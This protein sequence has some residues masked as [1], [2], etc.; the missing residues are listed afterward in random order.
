MMPHPERACETAAGKRGR[1]R[2]P[3]SI[4]E[5]VERVGCMCRPEHWI[6]SGDMIVMIDSEI[7]D[8]HGLKP[9]ST[10]ASSH[11]WVASQI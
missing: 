3:E 10:S 8:R 5:A 9:M 11:S 6:G 2:D 7:L 1:P 4:V